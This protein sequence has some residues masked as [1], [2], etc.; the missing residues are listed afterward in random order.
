MKEDNG[1]NDKMDKKKCLNL[2]TISDN[3]FHLC[4][5]LLPI[6]YIIKV[7]ILNISLG[8]V[9]LIA[10]VPRSLL[11]V[12][13]RIKK[14]TR[15]KVFVFFVFY[16]YLILRSDGNISRIIL[17]IASFVILYGDMKGLI[18]ASKIRK[19]IEVFAIINVCL[20]L[21]QVVGYYVLHIRVQYIPRSLIYEEYQNSYVFR[22]DGGLYRPSALFLEPSH[23]SQYCIFALISSFFPLRGK[24][25]LKKALA[26]AGGCILTTSG[27]GIALTFGVVAWY[28]IL[29]KQNIN[30][31][32][33]TISMSIVLLGIGLLVLSRMSFFQTALQRIFS[34]V[35]GYNAISGRTHNWDDAIGQ[36]KGMTLLFGYGDSKTYQWYL[37]GLADTIYKYGLTCVVLEAMCFMHLLIKKRDNFVW[38]CSVVFTILFCV[39]HITNFVAQVFYF[40]ILIADASVSKEK[41]CVY[42]NLSI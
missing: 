42:L 8:T 36:M 11:Y 31:K 30:M 10:Y 40:G 28:I 2:V 7:P 9:I 26:I 23:F 37:T 4:I 22:D 17:C 41:S 25:N 1:L 33:L 24:A 15:I 14:K 35:D 12:I 27:M 29:N 38:C 18:K 34:S 13:T 20:L 16:V 21:I 6:L 3:L 39:A 5:S 32:I 19:I